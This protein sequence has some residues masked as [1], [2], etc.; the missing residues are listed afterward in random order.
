[1]V[2]EPITLTFRYGDLSSMDEGPSYMHTGQHRG[3]PHPH[4][5]SKADGQGYGRGQGYY[6]G[7]TRYKLLKTHRDQPYER[8]SS[9]Y[10]TARS[11]Q[12]MPEKR[13]DGNPLLDL[14]EPASS[15]A[16]AVPFSYDMD[17]EDALFGTGHFG[18]LGSRNGMAPAW[19]EDLLLNPLSAV[20]VA[21]ANIGPMGGL[22][23]LGLG[24]WLDN[25]NIRAPRG[26][27]GYKYGD[28]LSAQYGDNPLC[29]VSAVVDT[30]TMHAAIR[31]RCVILPLFFPVSLS[32]SLYEYNILYYIYLPLNQT[33][34]IYF[35]FLKLFFV[36]PFLSIL[37]M[38]LVKY[39]SKFTHESNAT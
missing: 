5:D 34:E 9:P 36:T 21:A 39:T 3:T 32:F 26:A 10:D 14:F 19:V 7:E 2:Q 38:L 31:K 17:S 25:I 18:D 24:S 16:S 11:Q 6:A 13:F 37:C 33:K 28:Y 4:G 27:D 35:Y 22:E 1:M 12:R 23:S 15:S 8:Y 20:Q 29:S 30:R